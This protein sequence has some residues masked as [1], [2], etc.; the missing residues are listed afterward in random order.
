MGGIQVGNSVLGSKKDTVYRDILE[1]IHHQ[2][3]SQDTVLRD[4]SLDS[5]VLG[6]SQ[7]KE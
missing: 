4:T 5:S 1:D 6:S 3:S 2:G 7:G